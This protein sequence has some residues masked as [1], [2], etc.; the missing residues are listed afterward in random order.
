MADIETNR[1]SAGSVAV[2]NQQARAEG[3]VVQNPP[4]S[5]VVDTSLLSQPLSNPQAQDLLST[6]N[7]LRSA[8]II[9]TDSGLNAKTITLAQSQA[10]PP[11]D[12]N[13]LANGEPQA[14]VSNQPGVG[15]RGDDSVPVTGNT[16]KDIINAT[17]AKNT[18]Q[19]IP[20]QPNVLDDYASYTYQ[21]SWYLLTPQQYNNL[22]FSPKFNVAS[23]SL[24]MQSGG[25]PLPTTSNTSTVP[26]FGSRSPFFP[27][28]YYIDDLELFSKLPGKGT[29]MPHNVVD[30][31][32]KVV[33]PNGLTLI[34]KLYSAVSAIYGPGADSSE[35]DTGGSLAQQV[36]AQE[37]AN[38][39]PPSRLSATPNYLTAQY[40]LGI[41]FHGYDSGGNLISPATGKF[42]TSNQNNNI[43]PLGPSNDPYAI[44][45]KYYPFTIKDIK[46]RMMSRQVE[47]Y[48]EA[49]P[50]SQF[51]AF[52]QTRGTIPY[53]FEL[54]GT[55]VKDLLIGKTAQSGLTPQQD[56]R[57]TQTT[58]PPKKIPPAPT[59]PATLSSIVTG[60]DNPLA[61]TGGMDFTAGNF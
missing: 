29:G 52:G 1:D 42:D 21:I 24:L 4:T 18:N 61:T 22:V 49:A 38:N 12:I 51:N 41:K 33:E 28:D 9:P 56:G 14:S 17:F 57:V 32:F 7:R 45:E 31:K 2:D 54:S 53:N 11:S 43:S 58:P 48:I 26:T 47:Y 23:W 10:T 50:I 5:A 44:V 15:A 16:A 55:T 20:T 60:Q 25:A 40:C 6:N 8:G 36:A 37:E 30:I 46:F 35:L 3:A 19:Y 34:Q 13:A 39:L 27:V 59:V